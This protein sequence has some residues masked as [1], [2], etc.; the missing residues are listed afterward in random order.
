MT[1]HAVIFDFEDTLAPTQDARRTAYNLAF[2][3]LNVGTYWSKPLFAQ[4]S[5]M[6]RPGQEAMAW[7]AQ[8]A[9]LGKAMPRNWNRALIERRSR[10]ALLNF[11][12]N[13]FLRLSPGAADTL[14]NLALAGY[15]AC[16]VSDGP[17]LEME[18]VLMARGDRDLLDR[19][20]CLCGA[21][22]QALPEIGAAL[23]RAADACG[24]AENDC[25]LVSARTRVL[26][27]AAQLGFKTLALRPAPSGGAYPWH[28]SRSDL[29]PDGQLTARIRAAFAKDISAKDPASEHPATDEA[30]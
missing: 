18:A 19:L 2:D 15:S 4:I 25:L 28:R 5:Q 7:Q 29:T 1:R 14:G 8:M 17:R 23:E 20:T 9:A 26:D 16:V 27:R 30:A 6:C 21:E 3:R 12:E 11:I 13:G 24:V 22:D 10:D